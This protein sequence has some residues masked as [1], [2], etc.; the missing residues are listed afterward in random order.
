MPPLMVSEAEMNV[1]T[2]MITA[3]A[4]M[5]RLAPV[6]IEPQEAMP[7]DSRTVS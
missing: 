4:M 2:S 5:V 7:Q 3:R 6:V 1:P